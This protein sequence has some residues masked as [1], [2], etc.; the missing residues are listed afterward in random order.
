VYA[1]ENLYLINDQI[2][3]YIKE[4][5]EIILRNFGDSCFLLQRKWSGS[6]I[7]PIEIDTYDDSSHT[8]FTLWEGGQNPPNSDHPDVRIHINDGS[9]AITVE[10]D[11][12]V[13]TRVYDEDSLSSSDEF[14]VATTADGTVKVYLYESGTTVRVTYSTICYCVDPERSQPVSDCSVCYG[15]GFEGGFDVY[16]GSGSY[17]N[18]SGTILV[19]I[20][21]H[22]SDQRR[23]NVRGFVE[24]EEGEAW[25]LGTPEIKDYDVIVPVTGDHVGRR[26]EIVNPKRSHLRNEVLSQR[27]AVR[28]IEPTHIVYSFPTGSV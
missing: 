18:Q 24:E 17:Y 27:F 28:Y 25:T 11:G 19:R 26:Y 6:T 5:N 3:D 2:L 13:L 15:T 8:V 4:N 23:E 9:G 22:F 21:P 14:A 12:S 20:P 1:L 10:K 16:Q 7:G